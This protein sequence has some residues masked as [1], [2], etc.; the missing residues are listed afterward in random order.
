MQECQTVANRLERLEHIG[1][2][3]VLCQESQ[4]HFEIHEDALG[5]E[6]ELGQTQLG[7]QTLNQRSTYK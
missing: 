1:H 3:L 6:C 7:R 2:I 4:L 5:T